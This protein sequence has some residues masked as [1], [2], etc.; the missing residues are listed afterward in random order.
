[1]I[2]GRQLDFIFQVTLYAILT[3]PYLLILLGQ[4]VD[5][6]TAV[7]FGVGLVGSWFTYQRGWAKPEHARWW[8]L[9]IIAVLVFSILQFFLT[10]SSVLDVGIRFVM[11]LTLIKLFSR[12]STRDEHQLYLLSFSLLAVATT[13]NEDLTFGVLFAAYV[14]IGTISL[15]VFHLKNEMNAHPRVAFRHPQPMTRPYMMV[16]F[17]MSIAILAASTAIFFSFPRVGLGYFVSQERDHVSMVGFSESVELGGHGVVRDNPAVVLRVEFDGEPPAGLSGTHWRMMA[18]DE[19][20]GSGWA[21]TLERKEKP[22]WKRNG[23]Y[24]LT[25]IYPSSESDQE[26]WEI[27]IEPLQTNIVPTP[28]PARGIY[29]GTGGVR[30]PFG[31]RSGIMTY[32]KYGDIRH[33]VES[34]LGIAYRIW[35]GNP[36][37]SETGK[38]TFAPEEEEIYLQLP[39]FSDRFGQLVTQIT[40]GAE[41]E[42]EK[43]DAVERWLNANLTYTTDL[44]KVGANPVESFLFEAKRG[45]CEYFATSAVMMLRRAGVKARLVNGFL[46]GS[47][48]DVGGYW[49][50]R[51]GDAHSWV[52]YWDPRFGWVMLDPTPAT[53]MPPTNAV[54][55]TLRSYLDAARLSWMKWII[56]Y[57]LSAQIELMRDLGR[58]LRPDGLMQ[59][60]KQGGSDSDG[61]PLPW[62]PLVVGVIFV[63]ACIVSFWIGRYQSKRKWLVAASSAGMG[64]AALLTELY[65]VDGSTTLHVLMGAGPLLATVAGMVMAT[66]SRTH[67]DRV[68]TIFRRVEKVAERRGYKRRSDEGAGDFLARLD[69]LVDG[70]EFAIFRT[71]YLHARFAGAAVAEDELEALERMA[72]ELVE[73]LKSI[74]RLADDRLTSKH[75][76]R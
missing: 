15:A 18:F 76:R 54:M 46:G 38:P 26:P 72:L 9:V 62:R 66:R 50:V 61:S 24:G 45:H 64:G 44:P 70:N 40:V 20:D 19:Y 3:I 60:A 16:L 14:I 10:D 37:T 4:G 32:D 48:N 25:Q 59:N 12:A 30:I 43:A 51:Q 39:P 42:Q 5:P 17:G 75:T 29:L 57:D 73:M 35:P 52:E 2:G 21:R 36:P 65:L 1:M 6:I 23:R 13:V 11:V 56:E 8:N 69:T 63:I 31:P 41:T 53:D 74:E 27:Y 28:W 71:S 34:K 7:V 55:N 68:R 67:V 22:L 49:S 47:F 33:T 58:A